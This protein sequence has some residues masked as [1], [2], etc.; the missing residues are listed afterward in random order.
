[1]EDSD[2]QAEVTVRYEA[3]VEAVRHMMKEA[4]R[5]VNAEEMERMAKADE[6]ERKDEKARVA[7]L[8]P[9]RGGG[10]GTSGPGASGC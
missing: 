1:M 6:T 3:R 5:K 10:G 9:G 7:K 2:S 4:E 8:E